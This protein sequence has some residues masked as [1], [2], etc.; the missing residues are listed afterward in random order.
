MNASTN[1]YAGYRYPAEIISHA[2]WLYFR[3]ALSF[4]DIEELLAARGIVVTYEAV[5]QGCLKF[6]QQYAKEIRRRLLRPGDT[7]YMD[8]VF[9]TINGERHYL[10]RAM[11]QDGDVLDILVQK[12]R[13]KRAAKRFFRKLLKGLRYAPRRIVT[14]KLR[15]YGAARK[16]VMTDVIHDNDKWQNNQAENSHQPTR[17]RERQRRRFKSAGQAQRFL[18]AHGPINNLFR[19]GRHLMSAAHY[20][21]FRD[22]AFD[23]W[24][25]VTYVQNAA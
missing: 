13:N 16:E 2:V 19:C 17:Q 18:S 1:P 10:W 8:E 20:R 22:R 25:E 7:W 11:D 5:R 9:V 4:R 14:D 23:Q 6:G 3:F 12:H 24:R 21:L 15:S